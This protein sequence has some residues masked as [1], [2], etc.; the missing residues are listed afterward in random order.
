MCADL[1][2]IQRTVVGGLYVILAGSNGA[3]DTVVGRFVFHDSYSPIYQ[4]YETGSASKNSMSVYEKKY[5]CDKNFFCMKNK[6][7]LDER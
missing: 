3:G 4:I 5:V 2:L 7:P 1:D 6:N